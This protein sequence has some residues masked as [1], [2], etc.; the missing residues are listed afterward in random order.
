VGILVLVAAVLWQRHA[1]ATAASA[2]PVTNAVPVE[3]GTVERSTVPV[4]LQGLGNVT[5]LFTANITARLDG[6]LQSVAFTEGQMVKKGQ[7][8]AQIDPRPAQAALDQ[9]LAQQAKDQGQL[10]AAQRDLDRYM[11]LAPQNSRRRI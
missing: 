1:P 6:E 2:K 7:L 3:I 11:K 9:A 4:Y 8:L 10:D 5:A